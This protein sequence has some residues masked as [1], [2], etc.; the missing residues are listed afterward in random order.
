MLAVGGLPFATPAREDCDR[1]PRLV[2]E[3][4][5]QVQF[6]CFRR[7]LFG[8]I[9]LGRAVHRLAKAG[10]TGYGAPRRQEPLAV[11]PV[12]RIVHALETASKIAK[13][14]D[15]GPRWPQ[16]QAL[17]SL[18]DVTP[19][20]GETIFAAI[21]YLRSR[22]VAALTLLV[23]PNYHHRADLRD[24]PEFCRRLLRA[25]G[26]RDEIVLH[27]LYHL[28]DQPP[29][30]ALGK[31]A[32][33]TLTAGEGEFQ[34][35]PFDAAKLRIAKGMRCLQRALDVRPTGFVAPA[36]LQNDD[37]VRAVAASGLLW[38]EDHAFVYDLQGGAQILAPALSLA[39][40]YPL[41]RLGSRTFARAGSRVLPAL[42]T[43]R[44]AVHPGDFAFPELVA[45]LDAVLGQWLP[46]HPPKVMRE[47]WTRATAA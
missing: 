26:P 4:A 24:H 40:R 21:D 32:A 25:L 45:T 33:S 14:L 28:A 13:A 30:D 15:E 23:V 8:A 35:L 11:R 10:Q 47:I 19:A 2:R 5:E 36:W 39:S 20:H 27:G 34:A 18:H 3:F 12:P 42:R 16:R 46:D 17:I 9:A 6:G 31:F 7:V 41:R 38:C 37:V 43:V 1:P 22:G 44:L 29:A